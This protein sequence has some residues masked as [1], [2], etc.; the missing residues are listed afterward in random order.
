MPATE[1]VSARH[2]HGYCAFYCEENIW[3]LAGAD[4]FEQ[5]EVIFISGAQRAVALWG[6]RL[7]VAPA[8]PVIWDYHVV[9]LRSGPA[10]ELFDLDTTLGWP[11]PLTRYLEHTFLDLPAA[12]AGL[13]PLFRV[14]PAARYRALFSSD[15]SHMRAADGSWLQPPPP[16]PPIHAGGEASNLS[17]WIDMATRYEGEVL[18]LAGIAE[19]SQRV[20]K[21]R[22]ALI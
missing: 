14:V 9:L 7:A 5:S 17:R 2:G 11:V 6:Q 19:W 13:S 8:Q 1:Q 22:G 10:A 4:G 16:W 15:R 3:H 20:A 18:D 12:A 21:G